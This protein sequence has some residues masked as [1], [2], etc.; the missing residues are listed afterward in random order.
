MTPKDLGCMAT[1]Q[2]IDMSWPTYFRRRI[3]QRASDP[4]LKPLGKP[5]HD[6][7]VTCGLYTEISNALASEP[8]AVVKAASAKWFCHN[9]PDRACAGNIE[10]LAA[11]RAQKETQEAR[12]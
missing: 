3:E 2:N 5:C 7:A 1:G 10:N 11:L 12:V 4:T 6:C 8:D 9:H